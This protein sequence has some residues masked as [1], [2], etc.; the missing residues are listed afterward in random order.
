MLR[1]P[2]VAISAV[3]LAEVAAMSGHVRQSA[4]ACV[5]EGPDV[6]V[7]TGSLERGAELDCV[8]LSVDR[9]AALGVAED[10]LVVAPE[11]GSLV[12]GGERI[13][14]RGGERDR[15]LALFARAALRASRRLLRSHRPRVAGCLRV[16]MGPHDG[17][18]ITLPP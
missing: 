5:V 3:G 14:E 1:C 6:P 12:V 10:E 2:A 9:R 8:P 16:W 4:V 18:V 17:A 7:H 13:D 11:A 15:P